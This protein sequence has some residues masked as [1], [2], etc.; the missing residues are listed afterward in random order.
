LRLF[1]NEYLHDWARRELRAGRGLPEDR[2]RLGCSDTCTCG[3]DDTI[4]D[5]DET[6]RTDML[7]LNGALPYDHDYGCPKRQGSQ[8]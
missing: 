6:T 2:Q 8:R 3:L 5:A 4:A 7:G 1:N